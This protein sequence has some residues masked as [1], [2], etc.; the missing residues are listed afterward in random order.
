MTTLTNDEIAKIA[1]DVAAAN[2]ASDI[3][4]DV[5]PAPTIDS[6]GRDALQVTIVLTEGAWK[7]M[8]GDTAIN[9]VFDLNQRL[10][11]AG[12]D[13]FSIVRYSTS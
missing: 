6:R 3:W 8:T 7:K 4:L 13:R 5:K 12:E 1:K 2:L 11:D 9:I 10:Q